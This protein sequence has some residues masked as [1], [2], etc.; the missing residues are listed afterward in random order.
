[1]ADRTPAG[2][3]S[4][5]PAEPEQQVSTGWIARFLLAWVGIFV[6][7]SGPIQLLL[8]L[9][10]EQLA[11]GDKEATLGLVLGVGAFF[12]LVA[13]PLFG[14]VSDRTRSRF[15]R[16]APWIVIGAVGG[17]VALC[18]LAAAPTVLVMII[19]W[20]GVQTMLNA[21]YAGLSAVIPDE[22]PARQRGTA[23]GYLGLAL[24]LGI[25]IGTGIGTA[26]GEIGAHGVALGYVA[27]AVVVLLAV[28]P[29][30]VSGRERAPLAAATAKWDLRS[31]VA[32]FWVN[33]LAHPDFGWAWL[34]RFLINMGNAIALLYLFFYLKDVLGLPQPNV[35]LLTVTLVYLV[36][37]LASVVLAGVWSDRAG[38]RRV[39]V[40]GGGLVMAAAGFLIAGWT[41]W[42]AVLVAGAVLG[43]G[44]G[45]YSSVDLALLT[46]VLPSS[47]ERAGH[48]GLLNIASSLPQVLA[49]VVAVPVVT[50]FGYP[51]L[52]A[53]AAVVMVL[54]AVLV[55]RIASVR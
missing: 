6:G 51:V 14:V 9:Q 31:F 2:I 27:C 17:A 4:P 49:P 55:Y 22:V 7:L 1:M 16:R 40:C 50:T 54:G 19:G 26:A 18:V 30:L 36:A 33:P 25:A 48:L 8:P 53:V 24:I 35:A 34:T 10:A 46:Q 41:S 38:R 20:C 44:F 3:P 37:L 43:I 32:G 13:N 47:G 42:V 11:P 23:A 52:Y 15:G 29:H 39:F 45:A 28:V 12:S 21:S 5:A